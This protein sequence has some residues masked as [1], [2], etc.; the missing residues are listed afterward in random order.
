MTIEQR[1]VKD[2]GFTDN[3]RFAVWMLRDGSYINGTLEGCQRDIDH[4]EICTYYKASKQQAP[5]SYGIYVYKFMNRGNIR[6]G[7][8]ECGWC[9]EMTVMPSTDQVRQMCDAILEAREYGTRADFGR[10]PRG[11]YR[12]V[13]E[14]DTDFIRYLHRY[15]SHCLP[16]S[17]I[18]YY[19]EE[20]GI[21]LCDR[22]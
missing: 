12:T 18:D 19:L 15:S 20:T 14:S 5:G 22:Y 9:Y 7:C 13:W 17:I 2:Y 8:S 4:H 3:P 10:N 1:L 11:S 6:V 21:L 16:E